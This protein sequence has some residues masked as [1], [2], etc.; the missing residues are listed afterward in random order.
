MH[1]KI[2]YSITEIEESKWDSIVSK[3]RIICSYRFLLAVEKSN[4]ND[5]NFFYPVV[6]E[7]NQI[8]AHAC[9]YS[10]T[11]DL[12]TL[13]KGITKKIIRFIRFF[14][15]NFLKI[16]FLECGTPIAIGNTISF[17]EDTNKRMVLNLLV[18]CIERIAELKKIKFILF[19]DFYENDIN[20]F[21]NLINKRYKKIYNLPNTILN[22]HWMSFNEYLDN[23]R[24]HYRYKINKNL[25]IAEQKGITVEVCDE[26]S[27]LAEQLQSLWYNVY[28][29]AKEYKR[30]ILTKEFFENMDMYLGKKSKV[31][32]IKNDFQIVGFALLLSD[33]DTLR[34]MFSG[35]D[36]N[37]NK[38]YSIYFLSLYYIIIQAIDEGKKEIELGLTTYIPKINIGAEVINLYMYLKHVN[39]LINPIITNLL[40]FLNPKI[41]IKATNLFKKNENFYSTIHI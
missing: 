22:L 10:I 29:N 40:K 11:T 41:K 16:K 39:I 14:W 35:I 33:E 38:E 7:N 8:L 34:F 24:S 27:N 13:T 25:K 36:Y 9:T 17:L 6:Y 15:K 1:F 3:N 2:Y 4:I 19:R 21:N 20:L 32:L 5:C 23:L 18:D 28:I 31:I 26:F 37:F 30:E 12:D